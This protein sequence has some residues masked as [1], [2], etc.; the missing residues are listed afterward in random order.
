M[1]ENEYDIATRE[2]LKDFKDEVRKDIS[3]MKS[4]ITNHLLHTFSP[5]STVLIS[6]LMGL[7][8]I[9]VGYIARGHLY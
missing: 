3:D 7:L 8:G 4:L 5:T 1:T 2:M 6:V 9:A